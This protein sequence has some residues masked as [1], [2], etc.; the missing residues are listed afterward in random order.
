MKE[1]TKDSAKAGNTEGVEANTQRGQAL[2]DRDPRVAE[3]YSDSD[4]YWICLNPGWCCDPETHTIHEDT[5]RLAM[6]R[7]RDIQRCDCGLCLSP[8]VARST[9]EGLSAAAQILG[10]AKSEKK[11]KSSRLNG[12]KGGRPKKKVIDNES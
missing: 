12:R 7:Y 8:R 2:I 6:R 11:A 1:Q 3:H 4:G 9:Q 5:K 10:K